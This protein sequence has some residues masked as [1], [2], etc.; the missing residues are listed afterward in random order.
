[1]G[2]PNNNQQPAVDYERLVA[3]M[4]K[5]G[6]FKQETQL[7]LMTRAGIAFG[8]L[9]ASVGYVLGATPGV[10]HAMRACDD[11]SNGYTMGKTVRKEHI[12]QAQK[13]KMELA[14]AQQKLVAG[15]A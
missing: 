3:E 10:G 6:V 1:M 13:E 12:A 8:G 15:Q 4:K 14:L 7:N 11:F 5:Q 2:N 9:S